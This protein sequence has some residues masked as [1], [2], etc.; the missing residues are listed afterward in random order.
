MREAIH[1]GG[2]FALFGTFA[3]TIGCAWR[4]CSSIDTN[5]QMMRT[6]FLSALATVLFQVSAFAQTEG[7]LKPALLWKVEGPNIQPSYLFGTIHLL[8]EADFEM[9]D[10]VVK[11]FGAAERV[12]LELDMDDPN[13]FGE[14]MQHIH[15]KDGMTL[16]QLFTEEEYAMVDAALF[17]VA[18]MHLNAVNT[19]KPFM[20][21]SLF[22]PS[23]IPGNPASFEMSFVQMAVSGQKEIL[24]LETVTEQLAVF[25]EIPYRDQADD[26]V[27]MLETREAYQALY[28]QVIDFYKAEDI[29]QLD[30]LLASEFE[31]ELEKEALLWGR[32]RNWIPRMAALAQDAPCFFAVGAGHLAGDRGLV[33]LLQQAGYSVTP[34][35]G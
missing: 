1:R 29:E 23:F 33:R 13:M 14:M 21:S 12:V 15:M 9:K 11:A 6:S 8:P 4:S 35:K 5:D 18:K 20:L 34:I 19:Q 3:P 2:L 32:N 24:G 27:E 16:D 22:L 26:V 25:D 10:H 7:P 17:D 31:S 30:D 28:A